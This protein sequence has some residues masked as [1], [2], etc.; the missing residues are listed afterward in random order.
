M[1]AAFFWLP[2]E[3][4]D[5]LS[6]TAANWRTGPSVLAPAYTVAPGANDDLY[7]QGDASTDN[8]TIPDMGTTSGVVYKSLNL[9]FGTPL[10]PVAGPPGSPLPP[11]IPT[12]YTGTVTIE[13]SFAIGTLV[14]EC[15]AIAQADEY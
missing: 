6:T 2:E 5:Y 8:C 15:G 11:P 3:D 1:P 9:L 4:G 10:T 7:F 12:P 14:I 13:D